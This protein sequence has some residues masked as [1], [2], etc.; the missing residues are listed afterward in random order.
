M[1]G[2]GP[3]AASLD[4]VVLHLVGPRRGAGLGR[5]S[6]VSPK[7]QQLG[8]WVVDLIQFVRQV[9]SPSEF[10]DESFPGRRFTEGTS[11]LT[12]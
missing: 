8:S 7:F 5:H 1:F 3:V 11:K 9:G 6:F 10:L 4:A 12:D 2:S